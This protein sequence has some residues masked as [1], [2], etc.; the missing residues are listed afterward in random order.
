MNRP[1][2]IQFRFNLKMLMIYIIIQRKFQAGKTE[3]DEKRGLRILLQDLFAYDQSAEDL[4]FRAKVGEALPS[5]QV[6]VF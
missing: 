2:M 6:E 4:S 3:D 5:S 1:P